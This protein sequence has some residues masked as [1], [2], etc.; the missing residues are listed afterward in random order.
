[1]K[2]DLVSIIIPYFKKKKY[3]LKSFNSAYQQ[4]YKKKEILIVYDDPDLS[5][6]SFIKKIIKNKKNVYL[7]VNNKNQGVGPSRN[8]AIRKSSGEFL[9]FIDSDDIWKKQKL[10]EQIQFMKKNKLIASFTSYSIINSFGKTIGFRP[11]KEKITFNDLTFSCD[12]GLSTV[13]LRNK[14]KIKNKIKFPNL[15]TKE[16][17]VLWLNLSKKE[18]I[19]YGLKSNLTKWRKLENS[20]SSNLTQKLLDGFRVYYV[21]LKFNIF[22][23]IWHLF[24]LSKNYLLKSNLN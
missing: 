19:F 5:D 18:V 6:L 12:I 20:L 3:F 7:Y 1:M 9:A 16:D 14:K 11:A 15:K 10:N 13:I 2:K 8:L 4:I 22:K 17:Y 21:Y 24:L 23:S